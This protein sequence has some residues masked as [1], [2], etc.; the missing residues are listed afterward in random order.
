MD[1]AVA[2]TGGWGHSQVGTDRKGPLH[3]AYLALP[4]FHMFFFII[5]L[6]FSSLSFP[7]SISSI[8]FPDFFHFL[9]VE[10]KTGWGGP[11]YG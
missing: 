11:R 4:L 8:I 1:P 7:P 10:P 5:P 2:W 3:H 6:S 9:L